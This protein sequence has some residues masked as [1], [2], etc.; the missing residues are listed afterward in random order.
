MLTI[1]QL[2]GS[3]LEAAKKAGVKHVNVSI[4]YTAQHAAAI[5]AAQ[6]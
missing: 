6:L 1:L 3:A 4:S 2:H 5:A